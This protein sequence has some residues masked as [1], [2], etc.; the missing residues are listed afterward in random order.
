M[1]ENLPNLESAFEQP[2]VAQLARPFSTHKPRILMLYGSVRERP[3]SRLL[4]L[5][6]ARLAGSLWSGS[7]RLSSA[8]ATAARCT[9]HRGKLSAL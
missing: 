7:A 2:D 5:E 9:E 4:T 1:L 6:A 3:Y 8:P